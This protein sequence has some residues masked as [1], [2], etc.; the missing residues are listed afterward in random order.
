MSGKSS[1]RALALQ[2]PLQRKRLQAPRQR[3]T[4]KIFRARK[5]AASRARRAAGT[6]P[7]THR[8][9]LPSPRRLPQIIRVPIPMGFLHSTLY[10]W[11]AL[12][13]QGGKNR[14]GSLLLVTPDMTMMANI[15][16]HILSRHGSSQMVLRLAAKSNTFARKIQNGATRD[17]VLSAKVSARHYPLVRLQALKA[18]LSIL[19]GQEQSHKR[20]VVHGQL[21][22]CQLSSWSRKTAKAMILKGVAVGAIAA[23]PT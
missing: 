7:Q 16:L 5:A 1:E 22:Q 21:A 9:H 14:L 11:G 17:M 18:M 2:R 23:D 13:A 6:P 12:S 20:M 3:P 8:L 19:G 4:A 15:T 10:K